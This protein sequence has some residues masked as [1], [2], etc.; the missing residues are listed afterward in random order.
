M[1]RKF[2]N[3]NGNPLNNFPTYLRTLLDQMNDLVKWSI[4]DYAIRE[5][6]QGKRTLKDY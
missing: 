1:A 5:A 2:K 6:S 3:R 4:L